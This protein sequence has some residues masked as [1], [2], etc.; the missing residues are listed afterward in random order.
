M[1]LIR[2]HISPSFQFLFLKYILSGIKFYPHSGYVIAL[3]SKQIL[4]SLFHS[5][6]QLFFLSRTFEKRKRKT[7]LNF[8]HFQKIALSNWVEK[9]KLKLLP[10][11][12]ACSSH[13]AHI[14]HLIG[15]NCETSFFARLVSDEEP[16]YVCREPVAGRW[17]LFSA[18]KRSHFQS[19]IQNQFD[20]HSTI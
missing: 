9:R 15:W 3:L 11:P 18:T 5:L 4:L 13:S 20:V 2:F 19:R 17:C 1:Q 16:D 7:K 8:F 6:S 10:P 12:P 14:R